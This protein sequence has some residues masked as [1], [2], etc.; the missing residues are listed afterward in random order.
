MFFKNEQTPDERL[1][2]WTNT[3]LVIAVALGLAVAII[4]GG[5]V[6]ASIAAFGSALGL[7]G[8]LGFLFGIPGAS[9][10]HVSIGRVDTV[11]VGGGQGSK[12][13]G[14]T[15]NESPDTPSPTD[16]AQ[17]PSASAAASPPADAI[18]L[19]QANP[20][21]PDPNPPG[22]APEATPIPS[23]TP[24]SNL[25]QVAD[26]VTKLLLGGGLTQMQRI[27][28]KIWQWSRI[29]A[30]GILGD[31][32]ATEQAIQA[33]QAFAAGCLVYGFILGFFAGFLI[34]KLQLGKAVS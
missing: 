21:T 3:S 5:E 24:T 17:A 27:P 6:T 20:A 23:T 13:F 33:Q 9:Q 31:G 2:L 16:N 12:V 25:E 14:G 4:H 18:R 11:A 30:I 15:V 32:K 8:V 28:P 34:T 19:Q 29:V 1:R 10:S 26:W 22:N 7:G